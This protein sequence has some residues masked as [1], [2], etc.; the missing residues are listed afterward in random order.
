MGTVQ[1]GD[2]VRPGVPFLQVVDPSQM[3]VQVELNQ[4]DF[5]KVHPGLHAQMHLDAYPGLTLSAELEEVSPL[6]H[7]GQFAETVRSFSAR[8]SIQGTDSRL[9]PDL[10]AALDLDL[11]TERNVL[12]VPRQSIGLEGGHSFVWR[13]NGRRFEKC[14]VQTGARNDLDVVIASGLEEGAVVW[15]STA[16]EPKGDHP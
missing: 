1:Q 7:M 8:F 6:G 13:Q 11:G 4:V 15:R 10:S 16:N 14:T 3:E 9:L 2:E 12:V 5:L